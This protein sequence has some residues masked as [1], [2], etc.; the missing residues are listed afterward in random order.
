MSKATGRFILTGAG[1]GFSAGAD[2]SAGPTSPT[3]LH[4]DVEY[5]PFLT[6]IAQSNK[7]WIAAVHGPCA[8]IGAAVAQTC[9]LMVMAE[10]SYIYM[11][12]AAIAL[13]PQDTTIFAMSAADNIRFGMPE[14]TDEQVVEAAKLALA[15]EFISQMKDGYET[16]VGERG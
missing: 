7:V 8:G 13:V 1:R 3:A 4:L 11:A 2:L 16:V 10:D 6:G 14:A 15:D 5:K 9:D 12:F